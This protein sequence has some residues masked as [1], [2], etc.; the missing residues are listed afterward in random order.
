MPVPRMKGA[1]SMEFTLVVP[2]FNKA[3]YIAATLDA[4]LKQ[5]FTEFEL[6]VVDDGSTDNGAAIVKAISDPR[7]R[8][9]YQDNSGVSGARNHGISEARGD[10]IGFL[11][12]DDSIH[13]T[14]LASQRA[15]IR[16]NSDCDFVATQYLHLDADRWDELDDV[17]AAANAASACDGEQAIER[18]T[19]LPSR[20]L[21]SPP[22]FTSS[23]M[24]RRSY[25]TRQDL[26]FAEGES[27]G[28]DLDFFLRA[29]ENTTIAISQQPLVA[30]RADAPGGLS[31]KARAGEEPPFLE[32][33]HA[34]ARNGAM[35]SSLASSSLQFVSQIR[36]SLARDAL[37]KGHRTAAFRFL[38]RTRTAASSHRWWVTLVMAALVPATSVDRFHSARQARV[39]TG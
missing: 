20:W 35:R 5:S 32:R 10:W 18:V 13:P 1:T 4:A 37:A 31:L 2:L 38:W 33:L 15:C 21:K 19:D 27:T 34:R 7:V 29:A 30:Y 25:L 17:W 9:I 8:Y 36:I 28:E 22:F 24:F 12:A 3:Q 14:Y 11:D 16:S 26:T 23:V 39:R 6:I